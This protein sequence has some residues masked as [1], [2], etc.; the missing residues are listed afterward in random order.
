[1]GKV[2]GV[3]FHDGWNNYSPIYITN[4][5]SGYFRKYIKYF[6]V[7][8]AYGLPTYHYDDESYEP[9]HVMA[10]F[11]ASSDYNYDN[12]IVLLTNQEIEKIKSEKI[13]DNQD[14]RKCF[15]VDVTKKN[16]GVLSTCR[17]VN[18]GLIT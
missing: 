3:V 9:N 14:V 16:C 17:P 13:F 4:L 12:K 18:G 5:G 1:M 2:I 11:I 6:L 15:F 7:D 8:Y 10:K